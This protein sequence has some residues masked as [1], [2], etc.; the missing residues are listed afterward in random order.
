MTT[1]DQKFEILNE[2]IPDFNTKDE[3]LGILDKRVFIFIHCNS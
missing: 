2:D 3:L 1:I